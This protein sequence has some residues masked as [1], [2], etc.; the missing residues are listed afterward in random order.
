M[1]AEQAPARFNSCKVPQVIYK[2]MV[3][4]AMHQLKRPWLVAGPMPDEN[5]LKQILLKEKETLGRLT[6]RLTLLKSSIV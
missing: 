1:P 3:S 6:L 5:L 4:K 2:L